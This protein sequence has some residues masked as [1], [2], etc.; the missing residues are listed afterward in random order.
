M[1]VGVTMLQ[2]DYADKLAPAE[3]R[4]GQKRLITIFWQLVKRSKAR[5]RGGIPRKRYRLLVF[6]YPA[7]DYLAHAQPQPANFVRVGILG[8]V[9]DQS[10]GFE[11]IDKA[12]IALHDRGDEFD[13]ARQYR[14]ERIG[15][16]NATTD[17]VQKINS[18]AFAYTII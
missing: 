5:I 14:V 17:L 8:G 3:D 2:V 11:Q 9:Q 6:R 12:R 18:T 7:R 4:H 16:S 13:H 1:P 15:G 10:V